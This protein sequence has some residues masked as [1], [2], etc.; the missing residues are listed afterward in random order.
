MARKSFEKVTCPKCGRVY[1]VIKGAT[2]A[3]HCPGRNC[4]EMVNASAASTGK[5]AEASQKA[6]S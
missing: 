4:H 2:K 1:A 6:Q 3:F 5:Q